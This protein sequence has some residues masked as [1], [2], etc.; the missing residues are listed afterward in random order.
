MK[1]VP[2]MFVAALALGLASPALADHHEEEA[3][4]AEVVERDDDGRATKVSV[5]GVVYDV[6]TE[7]Q[8][9]GCINPR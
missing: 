7:G 3:P 5:D 6:C 8:T 9:D 2:S 4:K 1:P